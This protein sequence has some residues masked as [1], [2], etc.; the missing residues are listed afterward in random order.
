VQLYNKIFR[1]VV[2]ELGPYAPDADNLLFMYQKGLKP[3]VRTQVL[4]ADPDKLDDAMKM[5]ERVDQTL[6]LNGRI[7]SNKGGNSY[8]PMELGNARADTPRASTPGPRRF[9][10]K[11]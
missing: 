3:A 1:E 5:A 8:T 6:Y 4:I 7:K 2:V 11:G 9:N 10:N